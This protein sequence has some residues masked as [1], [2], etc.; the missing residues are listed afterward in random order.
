M[1]DGGLGK[2]LL[3]DRQ[4]AKTL[5][6]DQDLVS[7][8]DRLLKDVEENDDLSSVAELIPCVVLHDV[9][10]LSKSRE[11]YNRV[12]S[13]NS[14]LDQFHNFQSPRQSKIFFMLDWC[15]PLSHHEILQS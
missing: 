11:N 9:S 2:E 15:T 12:Y 6:E 13:E 8:T 14:G 1:R 7:K 4:A 3:N 5:T 10:C